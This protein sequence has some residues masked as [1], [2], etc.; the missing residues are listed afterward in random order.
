LRLHAVYGCANER[1]VGGDA[2]ERSS[3]IGFFHDIPL[4]IIDRF[5][6]KPA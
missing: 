6:P 5:L 2:C 1:L 4:S 3:Q